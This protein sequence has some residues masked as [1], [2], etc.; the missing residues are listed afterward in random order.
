MLPRI[1]VQGIP[2]AAQANS[3]GDCLDIWN[4][5]TREYLPCLLFH[6]GLPTMRLLPGP[7]KPQKITGG[8]LQSFGEMFVLDS[9]IFADS[10]LQIYAATRTS[11]LPNG[12]LIWLQICA[13]ST[14]QLCL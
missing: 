8:N 9:A 13:S 3:P 4:P 2:N 10:T 14:S 6:H 7:T 11:G 1:W 12:I 5:E